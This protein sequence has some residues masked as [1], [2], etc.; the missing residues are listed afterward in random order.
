[1]LSTRTTF[2]EVTGRV[3][4]AYQQ[5][6]TLVSTRHSPAEARR[7]AAELSVALRDAT[8][9]AVQ[10]LRLAQ[11]PPPASPGRRRWRPTSPADPA[12]VRALSTELVR[13]SEVAGW[14]RRTTLD[15]PGVRL[16]AA[17]RVVSRAASGPHMAGLDFEPPDPAG[18]LHDR[19]ADGGSSPY[20]GRNALRAA[21]RR[22][23]RRVSTRRRRRSG[24]WP[25]WLT[26]PSGCPTRGCCRDSV[27]DPG[28]GCGLGR[29]R[30][31]ERE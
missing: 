17:V 27:R 26:R 14:L 19:R 10:V 22:W 4:T 24:G 16:P 25:P 30:P 28:T 18:Q 6:Q 1:M 15:D 3:D 9:A 12:A 23:I 11:L 8:A 31:D 20:R 29:T 7:A 13:L 5:M 21:L 2:L